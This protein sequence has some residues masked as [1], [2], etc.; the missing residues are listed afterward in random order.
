MT[1][2]HL[3]IARKLFD[4]LLLAGASALAIGA[5]P[6]AAHAQTAETLPPTGQA[7]GDDIVVT[8]YQLQNVQS[9]EEKRN[10][11]IEADFLTNDETG[12]QPDFNVADSLR[13]L[14]GVDT[15]YDEDEGRYVAIRGMDPDYTSGSLDGA[16]LASSERNNR[17]LN[18]EA[19]PTTAI[20]RS[21]VRKSRTPDMEGNAIGGSIDLTTR[22]AF[23]SSGMFLVANAYVGAYDST[24]VPVIGR[25]AGFHGRNS[26]PGSDGV[27]FRGAATFS[28]KFGADKQFGIVA[29]GS[30]LRRQRDQERYQ[31]SNYTTRNGYQ[32]PSSI[33]A[34][35]YPLSSE[36]WSLFGKL[37]YKPDSTFYTA[38]TVAHFQQDE[39]EYRYL[40]SFFQR[41]TVSVSDDGKATTDRG[42]AYARF[43]DFPGQKPLTTVNGTAK[44]IVSDSSSI[45]A[46]ASWSRAKFIEPSN[47]VRFITTNN[48]TNLGSSIDV[49]GSTPILTV[50]N[51]G[52]YNNPANYNFNYFYAGGD[53]N[54]DTVKE[55]E[56][57]YGYN[58]GKDDQGFGVRVGGKF[59]RT[60]R[61]YDRDQ[62]NYALAPGNALTMN[63]FYGGSYETRG[64]TVPIPV[65]NFEKFYN[66]FLANPGRFIGTVQPDTS[67]YF[68]REDVLAGYMS[69]IYR[70]DRLS[71][72]YG[73]RVEDT[74]TQVVRPSID[75]DGVVTTVTRNGGYT[76]FL[77]SITLYYDIVDGLR[78]RGSFYQGVGRPNPN[79]LAAGE[80]YSVD[81]DGAF[82]T[83]SR[84]NP[85]LKA[86][87]ADSFSA[88][89]EYYFP[90]N[91][92]IASV[93]LFRKNV[94]NDI[95]TGRTS[96]IFNGEEVDFLQPQN[97]AG[98][99]V[100]GVELNFVKNKLE[101]LPGPLKDFG[102]STN[103]T[104]LRGQSEVIM[105]DGSVRKLDYMREQPR[106]LFNAS[107]FYESGPFQGRLSYAYKTRYLIGVNLD[108]NGAALDRYEEPYSQVDFQVRLKANERLELIAEARN[109]TDEYRRNYQNL[110]APGLRDYNYTGRAFWVGASMKF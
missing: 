28:T 96:G 63:E 102:V 46:R 98:A 27:S 75:A 23:D 16:S 12:Q 85:D 71:L 100:T 26:T 10:T 24:R 60:E 1:A 70:T 48:N 43:N 86:R 8:G 11:D 40:D 13:R 101:F 47:D 22:S 110:E 15:I 49:S 103:F 55:G 21:E 38:L 29:A 94:Q 3:H 25:S 31:P 59:R 84:G 34:I 44:W 66:Y 67:D 61:D 30:F 74:S 65:L 7:A 88:A 99:R 64:A 42:Q 73:V 54:V 82:A 76:N 89:L 35:G 77:P 6:F 80:R 19:I 108:R 45:D 56:L 69:G 32:V 52:Y 106:N 20:K 18:M 5:L 87:T 33:N 53:Y 17:R 78:L 9:I 39:R 93:S 83:V 72:V 95:F 51:P 79:Q 2:Y 4:P 62:T 68:M 36:R 107:V 41:G 57:N 104:Y 50:N 105:E 91:G 97:M 58:A 37:E 90:E 14:P 92:G 81:A 109:L